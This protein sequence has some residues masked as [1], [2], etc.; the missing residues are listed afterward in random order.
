[1]SNK[2]CAFE[3][4]VPVIGKFGVA[5]RRPLVLHRGL[6]RSSGL[7]KSLSTGLLSA[8]RCHM[9]VPFVW[10]LAVV[11]IDSFV[12]VASGESW[13]P[14][15]DSIVQTVSTSGAE[16]RPQDSVAEPAG[17]DLYFEKHVRPILK[18]HCFLCHGEEPELSGGLDLRLVRLMVQGGD[19]GAAL[20]PTDPGDSL[21][22]QRV[23]DDEMPPGSK[24]LSND[25]KEILSRW[26]EK[27]G[28]TLRPEP[29]DPEQARFTEEEL[30]HWAFQP[31]Q[32]PSVGTEIDPN[33]I[34]AVIDYFVERRAREAGFSFA[35]RAEPQ[36]LLRRLYFDLTGLPPTVH[37][38]QQF[39]DKA[40]QNEFDLDAELAAVIELLLSS[41]HYGERW[42]RHWLDVGG[43]AESEGQVIGDRPRPSAWRYLDYV[44][45]AFNRDL[46]YDRFLH[47][48]LAG[49]LLIQGDLDPNDDEQAR[50]LAATGFLQMAP[51]ITQTEDTLLNRNQAVADTL[52]TVTSA[53]LGL[54]VACAQCHDHRYDPITI[55]DYYRL[56]AVF[57][58]AMPLQK[59]RL[60]ADRLVDMTNDATKSEIASIE[61]RAVAMQ[62][63]IN[64]RRRA[65]CQTIQDRE[66][67]ATPEDVREDVRAAVLTPAGEQTEAQKALLEKFPKVRTIDWIVAQLV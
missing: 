1:M 66:I 63:D 46:P 47:E 30:S 45:D 34:P 16:G 59:W 29:D 38:W 48:Q 35:P 3:S 13:N 57:D 44:V 25:E 54:T 62:E 52:Q 49:D 60:P 36:V 50:L 51:D 11:G 17:E 53:V 18:T 5:R 23:L 41:P 56:R 55:E 40:R 7:V 58:P 26:V 4:S 39:L 28:R 27:G 6:L 21:L 19:S 43:Y 37:E 15:S 9:I 8:S 31:V 61:A 64:A 20:L 12:S 33:D 67:A 10:L 14:D 22:V 2:L 32:V 65:H 24:K 42:A